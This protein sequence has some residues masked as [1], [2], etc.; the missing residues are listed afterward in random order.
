MKNKYDSSVVFLYATGNENLLPLDFRRTIP[1]S[2][3][4]TW[5]KTNLGNYLGHEFRYHFNEAFKTQQW[6]QEATRYRQTLLAL[7]RCWIALRSNITPIMLKGRKDMNLRKRVLQ[8]IQHLSMHMKTEQVLKLFG[9]NKAMYDQ[10][11]LESKFT[12]FDS[13]T[14]LCV[15]RHPNQLQLKEVEKIKKAL[16]NPQFEHWPVVAIQS[17]YLRKKR[18]VACL[19][20]WYKYANLFGHK[21]KLVKKSL[22][23]V[24]LQA[25]FPNQYW[26]LDTT[27]YPMANGSFAYITVMMDNYSKMILGYYVGSSLRLSNVRKTISRSIKTIKQHPVK[28]KSYLVAD[29]GR[30]NHNKEV[31]EYLKVLRE[32]K[33]VKIRSLKDIKYSNSAIEAVHRTVKG[34]YLKNRRFYSIRELDKFLK[35]V[36]NDYNMLRPH[37]KHRPKT[38]YEVYFGK[39]L[40]FNVKNRLKKAHANRVFNNKCANCIQCSGICSKEKTK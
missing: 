33:I 18:M 4:S 24:G 19:D 5:R 8:S 22:K 38:P 25:D 27:Y 10:W 11:I 17:H 32:H 36:V 9:I 20:S 37:Y 29:G 23:R 14:S 26:H 6:Q 21:R 40:G 16:C 7:S 34:R 3:I 15:K 30:E 1:Y 2:T 12:C 35:W 39:P 13:Y 28:T 31:D